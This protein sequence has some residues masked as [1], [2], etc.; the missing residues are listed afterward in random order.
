MSW[1]RIL[2][3]ALLFATLLSTAT[4]VVLQRVKAPTA[5]LRRMLA[6]RLAAPFTLEGSSISA[7][8]G[9]V[10]LHGLR[11]ADPTRPGTNL[12]QIKHLQADFGPTGG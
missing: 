10:A 11:I 8:H 4:L 9:A 5:M 1:R 3:F 7:T 6:D 12:V 2:L